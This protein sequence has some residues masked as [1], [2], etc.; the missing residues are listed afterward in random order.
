LC[1]H[2][3]ARQGHGAEVPCPT[4]VGV[5]PA[6]SYQPGDYVA[7]HAD[8][9]WRT[10]SN[11]IFRV[12]IEGE[13]DERHWEQLWWERLSDTR[14][15]LCCIPFFAHDLSLGDE[16]VVDANRSILRIPKP[17]GQWTYRVWFGD[18]APDRR[19]AALERIETEG[20]IMEWSS[21]NLLA[22]SVSADKSQQ[23]ADVLADMQTGGL[24]PYEAG[25]TKA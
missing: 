14:F 4:W 8:P 18:V 16:V 13:G 6:M 11:F 1:W 5:D 15:V 2:G 12:P 10:R 21:E 20:P 25:R 9:V 24:L 22:L 23:F 3:A 19:E 17:S 7:M